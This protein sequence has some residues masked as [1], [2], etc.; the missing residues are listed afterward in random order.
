MVFSIYKPFLLH[1]YCS[2]TL[3]MK[4]EEAHYL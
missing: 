1:N 3:G 4:A 2:I